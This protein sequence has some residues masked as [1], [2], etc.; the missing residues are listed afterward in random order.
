MIFYPI[1][2]TVVIM[3]I[4]KFIQRFFHFR[5]SIVV[6]IKSIYGIIIACMLSYNIENILFVVF[7]IQK[8]IVSEK[9]LFMLY[10]L[11]SMTVLD[12]LLYNTEILFFIT[13][14]VICP[15]L[16]GSL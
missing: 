2:Y 15:V 12:I 4:Q 6:C 7:E 14:L 9:T 5:N 13:A 10:F 8:Q 3:R 16:I 1:Q 11:I